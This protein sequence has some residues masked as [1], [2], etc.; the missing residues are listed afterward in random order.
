[1]VTDENTKKLDNI[2]TEDNTNIG[3]EDFSLDNNINQLF[4]NAVNI[5]TSV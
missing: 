3:D 4:K 2:G 1:M 5:L